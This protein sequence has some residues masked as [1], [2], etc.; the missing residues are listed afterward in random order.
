MEPVALFPARRN[1]DEHG[2]EARELQIKIQSQGMSGPCPESE[3]RGLLQAYE[4]VHV[5]GKIIQEVVKLPVA[6][7]VTDARPDFLRNVPGQFGLISNPGLI[8]RGLLQG[9]YRRGHG[10]TQRS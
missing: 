6:I 2:V 1:A 8:E 9:G 5:P 10:C 4:M 7:A 3:E